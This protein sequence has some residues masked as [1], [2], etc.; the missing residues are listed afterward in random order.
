MSFLGDTV[1]LGYTENRGGFLGL[2]ADLPPA[3]R[4]AIFTAGTGVMLLILVV[5]A[6]RR[7]AGGW[8]AL[9]LVLLVAGGTSNWFDR[10]TGTAVV[11]FLNVGIGPLR[12]G[13]FNVADMA[14]MAGAFVLALAAFRSGRY[15]DERWTGTCS[16]ADAELLLRYHHHVVW[17]D[18][19]PALLLTYSWAA[20]GLGA[21]PEPLVFAVSFTYPRGHPAAPRE[22]Q[23]LIERLTF[24]PVDPHQSE[25]A[26]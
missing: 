5:V 12:T 16:R 25:T 24:A 11:D 13:V 26:P 8:S 1:R 17:I 20:D 2:G 14:T 6:V 4:V 21:Q 18:G 19:R 3:L 15:P 22:V 10:A 23:A 7:R 9:G